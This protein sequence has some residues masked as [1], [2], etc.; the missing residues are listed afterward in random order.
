M[1]QKG[2]LHVTLIIYRLLEQKESFWSILKQNMLNRCQLSLYEHIF[3]SS[4]R[5]ISQEILD[6]RFLASDII[7]RENSDENK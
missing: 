7:G 3:F 4:T 6:T 1:G 2:R 5:G